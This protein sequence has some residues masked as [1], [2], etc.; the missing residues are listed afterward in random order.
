MILTNNNISPLPFYDYLYDQNDKKPYAYGKKY[1]LYTP[2]NRFLPFQIIVDSTYDVIIAATIVDGCDS[3]TSTPQVIDQIQV[4]KYSGYNIIF[5]N[6]SNVSFTNEF[7]QG[8]YYLILEI[9]NSQDLQTRRFIYSDF[10]TWIPEYQLSTLVKISWWDINDLEFNNLRIIYD[11]TYRNEIYVKSDIGRPEYSF[12]E[13]GEQRDGYFFPSKQISEKIYNF[14]F[15]APE[16]MTDV[17]RLIRLHDNIR[18]SDKDKTYRC[19][20]FLPTVNWLEQGDLASINI[21]MHTNTVIKKIG[22]AYVLQGDFN[23][24][25]NDDFNNE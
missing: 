16:Y 19:D 9:A 14:T 15:I 4:K 17:I 12:E 18:V 20:Q 2:M 11:G 7:E 21:E 13:E 23:D 3:G 8:T 10:F 24:D 6:G 25:F 22:K 1:I 5:Y